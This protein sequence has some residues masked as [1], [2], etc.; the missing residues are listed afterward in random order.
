VLTCVGIAVVFA[1]A[2]TAI[3]YSKAS[4]G[5]TAQ[6]EARLESDATVV[7]TGVDRWLSEHLEVAHA[8]AQMPFVVRFLEASDRATTEDTTLVAGVVASL[9]SRLS[10]VVSISFLD[11]NGVMRYSANPAVVG[12]NLSNR[13]FFQASLQGRDFVSGVSR[14]ITD[15][16]PRI[17]VSTPVRAADGHVVGVVNA[18]GDPLG[19]QRFLDVQQQRTGTDGRGLLL[20][21]QGLIIANTLDR[22]WLLRPLVPLAHDALQA[23]ERDKRWGNTPTPA[24]LGEQG[25]L[26][27][28]GASARIVFSW[29]SQGT[30]YHAVAVPLTNT[31]WTYVF[32]L[33]TSTFEAT[34]QDLLRT[35]A[36]AVALGLVLVM[37]LTVLL[38]RPIARGLQQLTTASRRLA[39]GDID[40]DI[41]LS[42]RDEIG[43]MAD[44]F[45][46]V[47]RYQRELAEVAN[48]MAAGDLSRAGQIASERDSL[49][50]AF[51]RMRNSLRQ[52]VGDVQAAAVD[53]AETSA[54]LK[55]AATQTDAAVQQVTLAVQ[56]VASGAQDTSHTAQETNASVAQLSRA[57][58][59]IARG[60]GEQAKQVHAASA[61]A[62]DMATGVDQVAVKANNVALASQQTKASAQHGVAAVRETVAG[63]AEIKAVVIQAAGK[64][65][66]L[67]KLGER[68]GRVVETIDDIAEQTNLLALNAA[69]EAARAG[70]H[71]RGFAV[72]ADEVRKLAERSSRETRQIADLIREVQG[73]TRQAVGAMQSG[74]TKVEQGSARAD[75][76]GRAL[77]EILIA[78]D[79][80]VQQVTEIAASAQ[81]MAAA[82]RSVVEVMESI[83]AVVE[84]NT[85]STEEMAAQANQVTGA[86]ENIAAVSE[87]QS[88]STEE[89]SASTEEMSSQVQQMVVQ[90]QE[91]AETAEQLRNMVTGFKLHNDDDTPRPTR[92]V[93]ALRRAA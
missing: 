11:A 67:G 76:A 65:D 73:A 37:G 22:A 78:V 71:G 43:Q 27:A 13:D 63:M 48:A 34:T 4:A 93:V 32:A 70:E 18:S 14:T 10:D 51:D 46:E 92:D 16:S 55:S 64:V 39:R 9:T 83:S 61:T 40:G 29:N 8:V 86:I 56:N 60:A 31:H 72:V 19:L 53:V 50:L 79:S 45:R 62:S 77:G 81:Q 84:E 5:L 33:P 23:A 85:A 90:A 57:I 54:S 21:E 91:L 49:G 47:M 75:L 20:D 82:S 89:V 88:A 12:T 66:E 1:G 41:A 58:D 24:P 69:I 68:I 74:A 25:L 30:S 28:I 17:F 3:G 80:T 15:G 38:M 26:P 2:T 59:S 6:A 36:L 7:T 35:S 44:A 87:E 42:G 52:L